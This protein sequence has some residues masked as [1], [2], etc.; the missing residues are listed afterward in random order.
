M[1]GAVDD[2]RGGDALST[3]WKQYR[4]LAAPPTTGGRDAWA[5]AVPSSRTTRVTCVGTTS[6]IDVGSAQTL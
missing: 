1:E 2:A 6:C 5:S 3:R 4:E